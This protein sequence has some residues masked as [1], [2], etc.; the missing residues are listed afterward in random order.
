MKKALLK[1]LINLDHEL[2]RQDGTC[3][4]LNLDGKKGQ[5]FKNIN[6][7]TYIKGLGNY[8]NAEPGV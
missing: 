5:G 3:G 6:D 7:W 4:Q 2:T 8:F 1:C